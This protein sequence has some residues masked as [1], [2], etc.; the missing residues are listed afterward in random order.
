MHGE[1][2]K[3][4]CPNVQFR[5]AKGRF[6]FK[7]S[8]ISTGSPWQ[9][10]ITSS[11][12]GPPALVR[13][14]ALRALCFRNVCLRRFV[15]KCRLPSILEAEGNTFLHNAGKHLPSDTTRTIPECKRH[16]YKFTCLRCLRVTWYLWLFPLYNNMGSNQDRYCG[17][18]SAH[19]QAVES[20]WNVMAHGAHVRGSEGETGEWSG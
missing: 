1:T 9:S 7:Q 6:A 19:S 20:S 4:L 12:L 18:C 16:F 2:V 17:I 3:F 13:E 5:Y 8:S 11:W 14:D 10:Q 15:R